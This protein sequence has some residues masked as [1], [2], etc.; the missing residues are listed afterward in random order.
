MGRHS[1]IARY[2]FTVI[3][4]LSMNTSLIYVCVFVFIYF[5]D[6][7]LR[8]YILTAEEGEDEIQD[9]VHQAAGQSSAADV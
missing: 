9:H 4:V 1:G 2:K 6:A 5:D 8:V 7:R 3:C